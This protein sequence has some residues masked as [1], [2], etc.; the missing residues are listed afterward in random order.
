MQLCNGGLRLML[1][2]DVM[3][4]PQYQDE[5]STYGQHFSSRG[6]I[7]GATFIYVLY[8]R[9]PST[10]ILLLHAWLSFGILHMHGACW[11]MEWAPG[12]DH[13]CKVTGAAG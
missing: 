1:R 5:L 2:G 8:K 12:T 13:P 7:A 10:P 11:C 4:I 3:R 6:N 9:V